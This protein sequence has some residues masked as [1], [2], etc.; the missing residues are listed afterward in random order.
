M[1]DFNNYIPEVGRPYDWA[2]RL[3]GLNFLNKPSTDAAINPSKAQSEAK[4]QE[5]LSASYMEE[6]ISKLRERVQARLSLQKQLS[7]LG[8]GK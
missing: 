3:A 1:K 7:S 2:Q 8:R 5:Q 6:T 4:A